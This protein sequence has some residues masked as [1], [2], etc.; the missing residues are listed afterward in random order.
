VATS[1]ASRRGWLSGST[2]A[3]I[4]DLDPPG[5]GGDGPR[6]HQRRGEDGAVFLEVQLAEP[7]RVEAE[8]LRR[9][10]AAS[11]TMRPHTLTTRVNEVEQGN[12]K[13]RGR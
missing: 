13:E 5:T 10:H 9:P 4:P 6:H 3:A 8:L 12:V 11:R 7:Y 1:S 2:W